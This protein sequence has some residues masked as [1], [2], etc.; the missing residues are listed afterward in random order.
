M[1]E[2]IPGYGD[3]QCHKCP[4]ILNPEMAALCKAMVFYTRQQE[5][6]AH[7]ENWGAAIFWE[8]KQN[9]LALKTLKCKPGTDRV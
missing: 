2:S 7:L 1:A 9:Q 3:P 5:E 4:I 8:N 6:A